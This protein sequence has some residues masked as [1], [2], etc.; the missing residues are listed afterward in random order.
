M[1]HNTFLITGAGGQ[2]ADTFTKVLKDNQR[3]VIAKDIDS[4]DITDKKA[5]IQVLD[6][7]KP[8][9]LINCAAYTFVDEAEKRPDIAYAVNAD[10][11]KNMAQLCRE[12]NIFFIHFGT[13]YVFDGEKKSPYSEQ[14]EP[15][16]VNVYGK[17]KWQGEEALLDSGL[18]NFLILR[19]SWVFGPGQSNFFHKL[20]QW[21]KNND[22]LK[23]VDDEISVPTYTEDVVSVTLKALAANLTGLY[24]LVNSGQCSRYDLA[25]YY[26]ECKGEKKSILPTSSESFSLPAKRPLY[27]VLAK[28]KNEKALNIKIPTWQDAVKRFIEK[29]GR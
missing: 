5:L 2:L 24:H 27:S 1:K 4:L 26:F 22:T 13:D 6:K 23:I 3:G 19:L 16:P 10:A 15:N 20:E 9:V 17:S 12:R 11:V 7:G 25:K 29:E 8:D 18:E 21:S 28:K 14:D